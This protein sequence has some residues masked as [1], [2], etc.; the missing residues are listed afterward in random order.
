V[1][2]F[3]GSLSSIL[4]RERDQSRVSGQEECLC[5][6]QTLLHVTVGSYCRP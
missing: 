3:A 6:Q 2:P 1:S 4:S 5:S